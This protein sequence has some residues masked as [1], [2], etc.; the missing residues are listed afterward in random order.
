MGEEASVEEESESL[1]VARLECSG[2]ILTHCNLCLLGSTQLRR[3]VCLSKDSAEG[4]VQWLMPVV[5][6]LWESKYSQLQICDLSLTNQGLS[7]GTVS[8]NLALKVTQAEVQWCDL[9]S[10]Q[11]LSFGFKLFSCLSLPSSWDYRHLPPHLANFCI[12]ILEAGKFKI[13]GEGLHAASSHDGRLSAHSSFAITTPSSLLTGGCDSS[14]I[15]NVD[16]RLG[17]SRAEKHHKFPAR[18]FQLAQQVSTQKLT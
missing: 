15:R 17:D 5:P 7:S 6:S 10:L 8:V 13:E 4:R 12:F 9:S 14:A 2:M 18:L 3:Y 1:S 11:P 16:I